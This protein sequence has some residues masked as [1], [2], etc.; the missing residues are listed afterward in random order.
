MSAKSHAGKES[1]ETKN[2]NST[3]LTS[4]A[5]ASLASLTGRSVGGMEQRPKI[6]SADTSGSLFTRQIPTIPSFTQRISNPLNPFNSGMPLYMRRDVSSP[7]DS[8]NNGVS[9]FFL[10]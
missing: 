5:F 4:S 2:F 8:S 3:A 9:N 6:E 7:S 10:I 1:F